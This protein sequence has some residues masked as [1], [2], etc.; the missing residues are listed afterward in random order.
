[1]NLLR[2]FSFVVA[3]VF[4]ASSCG[5]DGATGPVGPAGPAGNADV[6]VFMY[7]SARTFTGSTTYTMNGVTRGK[8]D[9]SLIL[10]YFNPANEATTAWYQCPGLGSGGAYMT[11]YFVFAPDTTL[12]VY[13]MGVR[14]LTPDGSGT[15]PSPVTF[16][17]F[18][19]VIAPAS[20]VVQG[21]PNFDLSDYYSAMRY[22]D[23]EP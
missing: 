22:F 1:M 19:V 14:I 10:A 17:K 16:R 20:L 9:S 6:M 4:I 8:M 7:D 21:R 13:T 5:K 12:P 23:L 18:K 11:R 2:L 3:V 15:Y